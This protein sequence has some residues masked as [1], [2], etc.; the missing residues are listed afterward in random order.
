[1]F[2]AWM[3]VKLY[4]LGPWALSQRHPLNVGSA[5]REAFFMR[6]RGPTWGHWAGLGAV[7]ISAPLCQ[8]APFLSLFAKQSV[9]SSEA[10]ATLNNCVHSS[11]C[12]PATQ[13]DQ[14]AVSFPP[15]SFPSPDV[16][17]R[18]LI[19]PDWVTCPA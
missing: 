12:S 9:H 5:K 2:L 1:M 11:G 15:L 6:L 3:E 4:W 8:L 19:G 16:W 18:E 14:L 17:E 10:M 7:L 13:R